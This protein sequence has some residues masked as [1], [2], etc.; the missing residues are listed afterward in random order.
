MGCLI[1]LILFIWATWIGYACMMSCLRAKDAGTLTT[2][3]KVFAYPTL[4]IFIVM[5]ALLN[6]IVASIIFLEWPRLPKEILT[7]QRLERFEYNDFGWRTTVAT[8]ICHNL[9]DPFAP[10]G[11]HCKRKR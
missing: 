6:I 11:C 9:L 8:W 4:A 10:D 7:T 5:D 2:V 1:K 3:G